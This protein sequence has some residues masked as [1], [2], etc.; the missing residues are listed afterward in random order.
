MQTQTSIIYTKLSTD[1]TMLSLLDGNSSDTH[2]Y[3]F[4]ANKFETFPC[5]TY[6]EVGSPARVIPQNS[7]DMVLEFHIFSRTSRQNVE[8]IYTRL[9]NLLNYYYTSS[10]NNIFWIRRTLATDLLESDRQLHHKVVR[11]HIWGRN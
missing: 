4:D 8:D 2:I 6:E 1:A 3:P 5:I 11:F 9:N 10:P 7:E